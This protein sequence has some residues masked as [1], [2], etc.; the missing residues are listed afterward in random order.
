MKKILTIVVILLVGIKM[1]A[2]EIFLEQG[3]TMTLPQAGAYYRLSPEDAKKFKGTWISKDQNFKIVISTEK[4]FLEGPDFYMERLIGKYCQNSLKC[5]FDIKESELLAGSISYED[6][7]SADFLFK[8]K[9][10]SELGSAKLKLIDPNKALWTLKHR[11]RI[12]IN[13]GKN[14]SS[15][16]VPMHAIL[17]K[18]EE[19]K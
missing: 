15:F 5:S 11:E 1:N 18:V 16:S 17:T 6:G 3:R 14:D 2:Q 12:T 9:E 10:K 7:V 8:E 4:V 19:E 13:K